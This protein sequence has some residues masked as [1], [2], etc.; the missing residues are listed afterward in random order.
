MVKSLAFKD[1][2]TVTTVLL[3]NVIDVVLIHSTDTCYSTDK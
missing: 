2:L 1:V 3:W